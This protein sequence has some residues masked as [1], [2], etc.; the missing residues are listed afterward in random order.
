MKNERGRERENR[1]GPEGVKAGGSSW[2]RCRRAVLICPVT[3]IVSYSK[4]MWG[5]RRLVKQVKIYF[6]IPSAGGIL[7]SK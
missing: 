4:V 6:A 3:T 5:W 7:R 2:W 1:R